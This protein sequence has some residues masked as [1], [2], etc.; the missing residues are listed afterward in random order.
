MYTGRALFGLLRE[1]SHR[2]WSILDLTRS[3]GRCRVSP[4]RSRFPAEASRNPCPIMHTLRDVLTF[5]LD[6]PS[7]FHALFHIRMP[8]FPGL[9]AERSPYGLTSRLQRGPRSMLLHTLATLLDDNKPRP[10]QS[11]V[12]EEKRPDDEWET[13]AL[14][15][16]DLR[17]G[18]RRPLA[19]MRAVDLSSVLHLR[20]ILSHS[21]HPIT[22]LTHGEGTQ[23]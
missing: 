6:F 15:V 16:F 8:L 17:H 9:P 11:S 2:R 21:R 5:R 1:P 23:R 18:E 12:R 3:S 22:V 20:L 19:L 10:P 14:A 13:Y 7:R 4:S